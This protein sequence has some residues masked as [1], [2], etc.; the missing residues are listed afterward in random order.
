LEVC[1]REGDGRIWTVERGWIEIEIWEAA[2][3]IECILNGTLDIKE[4]VIE[5]TLC[6]LI[7]W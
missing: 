1:L 6:E 7:V 4:L 5:I 2:I 3:R